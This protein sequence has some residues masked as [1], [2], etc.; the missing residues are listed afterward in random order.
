MKWNRWRDLTSAGRFDVVFVSRDLA[1]PGLFFQR[2]LLRRNRR[3]IFDFDDAIYLGAGEEAVRW[4]CERAAWVTPGNR[5]L[6]EFAGRYTRRLTVIPTV[7]DTE[8]YKPAPPRSEGV[9]RVGWSGSDGSIRETLFPR[10]AMLAELQRA[11]P[12]ELVI[13][14]N[15][16]PEVSDASLHWSFRKWSIE[17]EVPGLQTLDI[18]LMPLL[19]DEFQRGKCGLK[20]LQYMA[21][22]R[23]AIASP[24]GVNREIIE[25]GRTG[26]LASTPE[27]WGKALQLL[28]SFP[29]RREEMGRAGR[30][31]VVEH[32]SIARWLP[33]FL[34]VL[35]KARRA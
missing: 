30:R 3:V 16:R 29:S 27:E 24:V 32:Y 8:R 18:G 17:D 12:F 10:L 9:V 28:V 35:E 20:V 22:G 23:P 25:H 14:S 15:T 11:I 31:R 21:T 26:M 7:I 33:V 4:M 6:A 19:D 1:G 5:V 2:D 13:I 34:D